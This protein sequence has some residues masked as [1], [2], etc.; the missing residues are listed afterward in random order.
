MVLSSQAC[1]ILWR[2]PRLP[3]P[4][5]PS[6]TPVGP[7]SPHTWSLPSPGPRSLVLLPRI[8]TLPHR[9]LRL[10]YPSPRS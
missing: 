9:A 5:N 4:S 3:H 6:L 7:A 1:R 2:A 10:L 8:H